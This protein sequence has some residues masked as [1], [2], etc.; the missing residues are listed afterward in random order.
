[1]AKKE[2]LLDEI[3]EQL[4]DK[5]CLKQKVYR[6]IANIFMD[7]KKEALGIVNELSDRIEKVDKNVKVE[8]IEINDLE[9]HIKFSG[10]MLVFVMQSN[11]ITF[12]D[13]YLFMKGDYFQEKEE[14]GF[15]GQIVAYNFMS[16]SIKYKRMDDPG[17]LLARLMV[18]V[19]NHFMVEGV[20]NVQYDFPDISENVISTENLRKI[21]EV[22][23][24]TS[25]DTDLMGTDYREIAFI[26]LQQKMY[27]NSAVG[28]NVKIGF[29]MKNEQESPA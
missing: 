7:L 20:S 18:N 3:Y 15:F 1:M 22:A 2:A 10:D 5:A 12:P 26:S 9:F 17:Y 13:Q 11:I 27:Q 29:Q 6:N 25:I 21:I 4:K 24:A 8:F 16:D 28:R 23:M 19:E 14:R